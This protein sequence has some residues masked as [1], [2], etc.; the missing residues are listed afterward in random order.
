MNFLRSSTSAL[1]ASLPSVALELGAHA[2]GLRIV[3][4]DS[5]AGP[6]SSSEIIS[7]D[8]SQRLLYSTYGVPGAGGV[9]VIDASNPANLREQG[10]VSLNSLEGLTVG[11]VS[12]VA[13]DPAGRGFGVATFIPQASGSSP[14][15]VVF[16]DPATF[17]VLQSV[18]VGYHPDM[19]RF[20]ADGRSLFVANE[21]EPV[22][23][24][25]SAPFMHYDRPGSISVID[26]ASVSSKADLVGLSVGQVATYDFS[27]PNLAAGVSLDGA[28]VHPSNAAPAS[29]ANDLEPEY[30]AQ[31]GDRLFVSL[32]ENNAIAEFDLASRQWTGIRSLGTIEQR[33]DASDRDGGIHI[34]DLV[35]GMPMPDTLATLE[36]GGRTLIL[37]ANE[38]DG[39]PPDH[40]QSGHPLATRDDPRVSELGSGGRP[41]LD[42][43][44]RASLDGLYGGNARANAALGR[45]RVSRYD[46]D[47]DA[48]GDIDQLTMFG[49][50]SLSIWDAGTGGLVWDS[51]SAFEE[52]TAD[53]VPLL[54]NSEGSESSFDGRSP[55]KGPEPEGLTLGEVNGRTWAFIGLERVG[56]VM[57]FDVTRPESPSFV[58]YFNTGEI[59]PEGL[60]FVP[61]F[62]SPWGVPLL[63]VGYEVS[64]RIGVYAIVPETGHGAPILFGL[65]A[66]AWLA[67]RRRSNGKTG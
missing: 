36:I 45:L 2:Q 24:G 48:D 44:Y 5:F 67:I 51:G 54:F 53:R 28:R 10:R 46:G 9:Q 63:F 23:E 1:L 43:D 50:R 39:R 19:V 57:I 56:G 21:G 34:D 6:P 55:N 3:P 11:S 59:A 60:E 13:A 16:F 66:A 40:V 20:S 31:Q 14:G 33:V 17:G 25:A 30:I 62:A 61:A 32:Q 26:L 8:R 42:P 49:T 12:S 38:G 7:F 35:H 18:E 15:R 64:S 22:S 58:D 47:L 37:T 29:R 41:A 27:T 65:G 52:I 4:V